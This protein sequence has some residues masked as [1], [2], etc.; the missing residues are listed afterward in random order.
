[1][2]PGNLSWEN[3]ATVLLS[4]R[5]VDRLPCVHR[6]QPEQ[7]D[8]QRRNIIIPLIEA[9]RRL[10]M[11]IPFVKGVCVGLGIK[12]HVIGPALCIAAAD[13]ARLKRYVERTAI[14]HGLRSRHY[15]KPEPVPV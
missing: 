3:S 8:K 6:K 15:R 11:E 9:A 1:M 5:D 12:L 2:H 14:P 13:F 10:D 4:I 7:T